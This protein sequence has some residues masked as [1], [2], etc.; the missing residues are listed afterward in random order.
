M[1]NKLNLLLKLDV[2]E[3]QLPG[4]YLFFIEN[5]IINMFII[6]NIKFSKWL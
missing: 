5:V 3:D 2:K 4:D 1:K 6:N